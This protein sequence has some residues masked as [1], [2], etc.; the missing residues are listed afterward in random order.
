MDCQSKSY[1]VIGIIS[2][3]L[4][5]ISLGFIIAQSII[6]IIYTFKLSKKIIVE[7]LIYEQFSHEV[8]S[9]INSHPFTKITEVNNT[10][11]SCSD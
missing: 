7:R 4:L 2:I 5:I 10:D 11:Y 9:N 3:I 6:N 1:Q 8:Y